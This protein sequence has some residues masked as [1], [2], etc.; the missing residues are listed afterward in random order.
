[1]A[2]VTP[3]PLITHVQGLA[4]TG[5]VTLITAG[6]DTQQNDLVP[7]LHLS[8]WALPGLK[9]VSIIGDS[10]GTDVP[11]PNYA[12]DPTQTIWGALKAEIV[13]RN[14]QLKFNFVNRAISSTNW[15][16]PIE[17]ANDRGPTVVVPAWYTNRDKVWLDYV[18]D[19]LP[20]TLF[21]ILGI[22]APQ[23]G[24]TAGS[25][26]ASFIN[27]AFTYINT[28]FIK[29][30]DIV[31]LTTKIGNPTQAPYNSFA[32][33][34]ACKAMMSFLRTFARSNRNGY[35]AFPRMKYIGLID[36]GRQYAA[37]ALGKDIAHQYMSRVSSA[38]HSGYTMPGPLANAIPLGTTTDGDLSLTLVFRNAGAANMYNAIGAGFFVNISG[39]FSNRIHV[40]LQNTGFWVTRYQFMGIDT[41]P[42]ITGLSYNPPAG[43]VTMNIS[44][45]DDT[46]R[47][48]INGVY[49]I[50][51]TAARLIQNCVVTIASA[52][53]PT[54][55]ITFDVTEF[56]E[57]IGAPVIQTLDPTTA[58]GGG[59]GAIAGNDINHPSATTV[60]LID[61]QTIS[62]SNLAAPLPTAAQ[63]KQDD[64]MQIY[65]DL[66][67]TSNTSTGSEEIL[68]TATIN[69]NQLQNVGDVLE[70]E[71]WGTMA[72]STDSKTVRVRWNGITGGMLSGGPV[73]T[74]VNGVRWR[75]FG[76]IAKSALNVQLLEGSGSISS[77]NYVTGSATAG[78][79][80]ASATPLVVTSTAAG[81]SAGS[82][83]CD[84]FRVSYI[85]SPG[86]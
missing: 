50:D 19:D 18:R 68:K 73:S 38:I 2:I 52:L 46:V 17:T 33:Q 86:T 40:T 60:A 26:V 11:S 85:R 3:S 44:L 65:S 84:G 5:P 30:P 28:N 74:S 45:K 22:N 48:A 75:I 36:L 10:T 43:D 80:D 39:F 41:D 13:R 29:V 25:S 49:V 77:I 1:M 20:D 37:R 54:G 27:N 57:G 23:S 76:T 21:W 15:A 6:P 16:N 7:S 9:T 82:V 59:G 12:Y 67:S 63:L 47:I 72:A 8:R 61:C 42:V 32:N 71:A 70:I 34:E 66:T 64:K 55:T 79:A 58:F 69:A 62:R 51:T 35:G 31:L 24:Q 14:P 4:G 83:T 78:V 81:S 56:L 53:A